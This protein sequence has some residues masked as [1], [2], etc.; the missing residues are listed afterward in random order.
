MTPAHP[1]YVWS[2]YGWWHHHIDDTTLFLGLPC[3]AWSRIVQII[4]L[5]SGLVI[6]KD[7]IGDARLIAIA[8]RIRTSAAERAKFN[9]SYR[10]AT[11]FSADAV[12][13]AGEHPFA[14]GSPKIVPPVNENENSPPTAI[15]DAIN[16]WVRI[17]SAFVAV[18]TTGLSIVV[19]LKIHK[20]SL[21]G[22]IVVL[23]AAFMTSVKVLPYVAGAVFLV[24]SLFEWIADAAIRFAIKHIQT[25]AIGS[26]WLQGAA[27]LLIFGFIIQMLTS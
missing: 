2:F 24:L 13:Y 21:F 6:F 4:S 27:F 1:A 18:I 14:V 3:F 16:K 12:E 20:F 23:L 25:R 7:I 11:L 10:I 19:D 17:I 15:T 5:L 8:E 22:E 26:R 9:D